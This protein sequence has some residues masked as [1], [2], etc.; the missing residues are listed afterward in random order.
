MIKLLVLGSEVKVEEGVVTS[1][2]EDAKGVVE[3]KVQLCKIRGYD[4]W[5]IE[6]ILKDWGFEVIQYPRP[7]VEGRI[8]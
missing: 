7:S 2:N 5:E 4:N 6:G 1:S 3:L 8:Y